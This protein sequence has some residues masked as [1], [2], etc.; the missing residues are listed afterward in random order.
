[1]LHDEE[2]V[3]KNCVMT[4]LKRFSS[5]DEKWVSNSIQNSQTYKGYFNSHNG[6]AVITKL[7]LFFGC[8]GLL[9]KHR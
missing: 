1:M 3:K 5:P 9:F 6:L 2:K 4:T 7:T 8:F